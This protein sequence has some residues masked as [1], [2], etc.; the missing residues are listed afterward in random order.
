MIV[1]NV[2]IHSIHQCLKLNHFIN[3]KNSFATFEIPETKLK[4]RVNLE[5]IYGVCLHTHNIY[6]VDY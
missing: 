4:N 3:F 1:Y 2:P 5:H 6:M